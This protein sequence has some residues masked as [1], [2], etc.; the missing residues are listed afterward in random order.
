MKQKDLMLIIVVVFISAVLSFVLSNA[1]ISSPKSRQQ[2]VEV[3]EKITP[4]FPQ[5][6]HKYFNSESID[7][8]LLIRIGDNTN[9]T[10]FNN[11]AKP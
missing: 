8:T 10:P 5:P 7:P 9:T 3:V 2:K 6:D 4:D 11:K 1:V